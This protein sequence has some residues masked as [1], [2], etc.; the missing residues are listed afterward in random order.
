[1]AP[2]LLWL[3]CGFLL[4]FDHF[5]E[6]SLIQR[7]LQH[8]NNELNDHKDEGHH[9]ILLKQHLL[10]IANKI[11]LLL[12]DLLNLRVSVR[13][14]VGTLQSINTKRVIQLQII[15]KDPLIIDEIHEDQELRE[16]FE[17]GVGVLVVDVVPVVVEETEKGVDEGEEDSGTGEAVEVGGNLVEV[18]HLWGEGVECVVDSLLGETVGVGVGEGGVGLVDS[19]RILIDSRRILV[20]NCCV[21]VDNCCV[22]VVG[23]DRVGGNSVVDIS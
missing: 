20:D 4:L 1:M 6:F 7:V 2:C 17:L 5:L 19:R 12:I 9:K 14:I 21:L 11:R 18:L 16:D 15:G 23:E 3:F 10:Q 8:H 22:L 13:R